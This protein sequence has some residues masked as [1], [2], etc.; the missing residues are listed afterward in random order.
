MDRIGKIL[1][2][3]IHRSSSR[4]NINDIERENPFYVDQIADWL[5]R[6]LGNYEYRPYYCKIA[7]LIPK[8]ALTNMLINAKSNGKHPARL[9]SHLSSK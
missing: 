2:N 4:F 5:A 6:E 7:R 1:N 8:Y 3:D 9:F